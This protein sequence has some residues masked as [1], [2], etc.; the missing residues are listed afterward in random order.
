MFSRLLSSIISS[1]L[2]LA[3]GVI[4][5]AIAEKP[6]LGAHEQRVFDALDNVH[7]DF[8]GFKAVF[9]KHAH[10]EL[11]FNDPKGNVIVKSG[12][13]DEVFYNFNDMAQ[14]KI[15]WEPVTNT[16]PTHPEQGVLSMKYWNYGLA[17]NGCEAL[18]SG[19]GTIKFDKN[20][21]VSDWRSYSTEFMEFMDCLDEPSE[22]KVQ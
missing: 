16:H 5:S 7:N 6:Y 22:V 15:K 19:L 4:P 14:Y 21:L 11:T 20:G 2:L 3:L 10:I 18:F 9:G 13:F 8:E 1:L 12:T 17:T